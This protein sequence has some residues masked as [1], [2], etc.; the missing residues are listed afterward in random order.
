[1]S[2]DLGK[3]IGRRVSVMTS[4]GRHLL[5][6]LRGVDQFLNLVLEDVTDMLYSLDEA[7]EEIP[8]GAFMVRGDDVLVVGAVDT[9][10]EAGLNRDNLRFG[11]L[12]AH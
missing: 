8:C 1:M 6:V 4:D 3:A 7:P 11:Y 9:A 5:G 2:N 10:E 12:P